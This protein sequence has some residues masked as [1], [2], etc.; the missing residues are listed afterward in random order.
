M[1]ALTA[2]LV[3]KAML[4]LLTEPPRVSD[5]V[6]FVTPAQLFG[7][8]FAF[9]DSAIALE[10]VRLTPAGDSAPFPWLLLLFASLVVWFML[11]FIR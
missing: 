4:R 11:K 6:G 8:Q 9:E 2:L 7:A 5:P 1:E 3:R 10:Y